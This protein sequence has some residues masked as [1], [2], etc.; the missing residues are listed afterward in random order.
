VSS[1]WSRTIYVYCIS[2]QTPTTGLVE[3]TNEVVEAALHH[4]ISAGM[5]DWDDMLP[6]IEFAMNSSYH[7]AIR[8]IPF[9][10]NRIT[11]P[12]N[13]FHVSLH[14]SQQNSTE[15]TDWLGLSPPQKGERNYVQAHEEY[16]RARRCVHAAKSRMKA[17][18][19]GKGVADHLYEIGHYVWFNIKNIALR[20]DSRRHKLLPKFRGPFQVIELIGRNSLRLDMPSQLQHVHPVV[21]ISLVKPFKRRL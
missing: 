1:S 18:H 14:S 15:T 11:L 10:T 5:S 6:R 21:S 17:M 7:E 3:R 16:Q 8:S 20:H 19:D 2:S 13:P 4:Y 9:R 12:A